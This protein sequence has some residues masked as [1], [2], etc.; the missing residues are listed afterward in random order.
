MKANDCLD[1]R[2]LAGGWILTC[3]SV[4]RARVLRVEYPD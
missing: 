3:Q 4:P 1:R 2:Q